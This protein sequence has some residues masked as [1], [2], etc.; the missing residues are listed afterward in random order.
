MKKT[1]ACLWFNMIRVL[2][3][4]SDIVGVNLQSAPFSYASDNQF[5]EAGCLSKGE[6]MPLFPK[7]W[8]KSACLFNV[9]R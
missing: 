5:C 4:C 9:T 7:V 6:K 2:N 1:E 3:D 8:M